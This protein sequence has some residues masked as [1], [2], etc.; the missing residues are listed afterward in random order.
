MNDSN[1]ITQN[2]TIYCKECGETLKKS[3]K[4]CYHCGAYKKFN[5]FQFFNSLSSATAFIIVIVSIISLL[6]TCQEKRNA[7]EAF[8]AAEQALKDT[9]KAKLAAETAKE[10]AIIQAKALVTNLEKET[11]VALEKITRESIKSSEAVKA[12]KESIEAERSK[13]DTISNKSQALSDSL[14]SID[15]RIKFQQAIN[16]AHNDDRK[17]YDQ[18][19][20][21]S[22]DNN[23]PF[24]KEAKEQYLILQKNPSFIFEIVTMSKSST[25]SLEK[26]L[27]INK[28]NSFK[29]L[30][31][32][33][34]KIYPPI[35]FIKLSHIAYIAQRRTEIPLKERL[36]FLIT[37][38]KS[39]SSLLAA[40]SA[41]FIFWQL[42][43]EKPEKH[44]GWYDEDLTFQ[45]WNENK[46]KY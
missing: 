25:E 16:A 35:A 2:E 42:I 24:Q 27:S 30:V 11:T 29:E 8:K 46:D 1:S 5:W 10:D 17:S 20:D 45:Y 23:Y 18:L 39:D 40:K 22:E 6:Q 3:A 38:M 12:L 41:E 28:N 36:K 34:N 19:K 9:Q 13:L 43:G 14:K 7:E 31:N 37:I 21:W 15:L 33:Y 32:F 4:K 44:D 26:M